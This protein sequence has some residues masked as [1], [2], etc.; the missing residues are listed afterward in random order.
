MYLVDPVRLY[1]CESSQPLSA[2][3]YSS[4]V[5]T[6]V[7]NTQVTTPPRNT[8]LG[9]GAQRALELELVHTLVGW[10]AEGRTLGNRALAVTTADT[11]AVDDVALLGL[12]PAHE[13]K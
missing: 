12:F 8:L 11:D 13:N 7:E 9:G 3:L 6:Y 4:F 1:V 5:P 2:S 10:L